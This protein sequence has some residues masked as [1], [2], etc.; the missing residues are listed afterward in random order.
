[1]EMDLA[2][3]TQFADPHYKITGSGFIVCVYVCVC[4]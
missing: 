3:G 2:R 4:I 1:M